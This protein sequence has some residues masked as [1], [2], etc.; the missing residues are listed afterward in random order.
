MSAFD[1]SILTDVGWDTLSAALAGGQLT[2]VH[3]EAGDGT[4]TGDAEMEAM[5]ALKNK[6]MDI[7]ITSYSDDGKGQLT[8][9]G[10]L[11]SANVDVAFHFRELGVKANINGGAEVLYCVCNA[12][13]SADFIPDKTNPAVVIQNIEIVV[14]IDRSITPIINITQGDVTAQNIG[15]ATVGAG[16]YRDKVGSV[17]NFKRWAS[18]GS[19]KVTETSDVISAD[20]AFPLFVPTGC[21]MDWPGWVAPGGWLLCQ[22]QAISRTAYAGIYAVIGTMYG[23]GDGSTTFNLPDCQGRVTIGT[24]AGAGLTNRGLTAKGGSETTVLTVAQLPAHTHTATQPAHTHYVNDPG[25]AHSVY[26]PTHNHTLR[27]P[28]HAHSISDPGHKHIWY[29]LL[30][31]VSQGVLV[32]IPQDPH[33]IAESEAARWT[34]PAGT[35]IGIYAVGTGCWNDASGT[36]IGIYAA[37]TGVYLSYAGNDAITVYNTGSGQAHSNMQPFLVLH[38]IIKI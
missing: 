1:H 2:F 4:V 36:G 13:D 21:M 25:H 31:Q 12:Y 14:K 5:T 11:S 6:I 23:A 34:D 16:W 18:T 37:G 8:L 19:V 29:S 27:D 33:Y 15:P 3:M 26:D 9:I 30:V 35:G 10:V 28:G 20:V 7:P 22:G 38:K 17:L 32:G 24:G